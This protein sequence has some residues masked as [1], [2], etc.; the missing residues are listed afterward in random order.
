MNSTYLTAPK[1]AKFTTYAGLQDLWTQIYTTYPPGLIEF[2]LLVLVQ[3]FCFWIPAA[4]LLALDLTFPAFSNRHKIQ[5]E[6]RQPSWSQI[7]H[8]ITHV[9]VNNINSTVLHFVVL[10]FLNFE[11]TLFCVTPELPP[12]REVVWDFVCAALAR[13]V[14]FYYVHRA[15]HDPRVYRFVHK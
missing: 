14:L 7:K 12:I 5:S 13:E 15:L 2:T 6:R 11:K 9:A 3:I 1:G 4:L 10:Y 8:C